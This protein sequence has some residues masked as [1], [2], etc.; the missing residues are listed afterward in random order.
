M[1]EPSIHDSSYRIVSVAFPIA[2]SGLY[3][4]TIPGELAP[5][6]KEGTPVLV[7]VRSRKLWGM[8]VRLK[9]HS[10][11]S[12]LKPVLDARAGLQLVSFQSL[13]RLYEWIAAYYQCDMGAVFKP[14]VRKK[15][16]ET[17][18]RQIAYYRRTDEEPGNLTPKQREAFDLLR[19]LAGE[20]TKQGLMR[21]Y[22][23]SAHMIGALCGK[24]VL[25]RETRTVLR[26]VDE[27]RAPAGIDDVELT[28]EQHR[29]VE[30]VALRIGRTSEPCLLHGITGSGKTHV[31]I[32]IVKRCL[33]AGKGAIVLVP[34]ISLTPQT[35]QRF[36]N[37]IG[38]T[39]AVIHSNMSDGE[40]RDGLEQLMAGDKRVVIGVRSAVLA[41]VEN[42]GAI[43]VDEEHDGSYKQSDPAP[44]YHAR[45]VAIMR[46]RLQKA[47]VVLGSAT[48]SLESY[49]NAQRGKY[50]LVQLRRRFGQASLPRVEVVDMNQEHQADN[51][52][53]LS[54]YLHRRIVETL[55]R[56]RQIILLLNRRGFSTFLLC[57][58]CGFVHSCPNC[59]VNLVYHRDT[60]QLR[61][62]Q[63]GHFAQAPSRCSEC[64]GEQLQYKGT[65]IQKAEELLRTEFP[66]ASIL[67]MDQ[68]TTRR[69]GSHVSIL[70]EFAGGNVDILLGTQMVSKGLDFPGVALVGVL[71]ADV[72]LH[73]PDFRGSE[74]T[75]QLLTQV[76]GRAGRT[77]NLGEVVIQTYL[78]TEPSVV[79]ARTHDY[80]AFVQ[81][82]MKSREE[83]HYPPFCR[84]ARVVVEN[85]S[86]REAQ[87]H[88]EHIS[89]SI[90]RRG[91]TALQLM[92]PSP[93]VFSRVKSAYR[94][95]L[96]VRSDSPRLL[97]RTL[98]EVRT[99]HRRKDGK[100]IIDVDPLNMM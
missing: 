94:F 57:K 8:A 55:Q 96:I 81:E 10:P 52:T 7:E 77:D 93:A 44:R 82:E 36:R 29:A 26:R 61:C 91:G 1:S 87:T 9:R 60:L 90:A 3:D 62:H 13:I 42:L 19:G 68:D 46:G 66:E 92:G 78:P 32:E 27:L 41:P 89:R 24:G 100:L 6:V 31:Y 23:L 95:S 28:E 5:R 21:D 11:V 17:P 4:Y 74:K 88:I 83:L 86:E 40:R 73:I 64:G 50:A 2:I 79:C 80:P 84:L 54:R 69:K 97:Q 65:G 71:Q 18:T 58:E 16:L 70:G 34:E 33:S 49:H 51:W 72:G 37:A 45:D 85:E 22:G 48:P 35:I 56:E 30:A 15:L 39:I 75:F 59:S 38:D 99:N 47:A 53:F 63:C 43:I 67:R 14:F 20:T 98:A 25:S 12:A 76:A